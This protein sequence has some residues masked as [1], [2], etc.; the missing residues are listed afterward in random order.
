LPVPAQHVV[1]ETR[2][3]PRRWLLLAATLATLLCVS[4]AHSANTGFRLLMP[5]GTH[6]NALALPYLYYPSGDLDDPEQDARDLCG[7]AY[8]WGCGWVGIIRFTPAGPFIG[9]C[10]LPLPPSFDL[11]PG[12]GYLIETFGEECTAVIA[13]SHDDNYSFGRGTATIRL[14]TDRI[15]LVAPPYHTV[16]RTAQQLCAFINGHFGSGRD[17]RSL[18]RLTPA[19]PYLALCGSPFADFEL[20]PGE[21]LYFFVATPL[22]IQFETY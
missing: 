5:L 12:E 15:N 16:Q 3:Q 6:H 1:I 18:V 22:E 2:S 14:E 7:I 21:A 9:L 17:L 8:E 10:E 11:Q 20:V 4:P 19:G 13:G